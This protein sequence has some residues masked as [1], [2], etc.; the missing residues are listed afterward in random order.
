MPTIC[1]PFGSAPLAGHCSPHNAAQYSM[2]TKQARTRSNYASPSSES[3]HG[4][5][6][7]PGLFQRFPPRFRNPCVASWTRCPRTPHTARCLSRTRL[8]TWV[9]R[10][11]RSAR[12]PRH[13]RT[14]RLTAPAQRG[15]CWRNRRS[16]ITG[17]YENNRVECGAVPEPGPTATLFN[18][19]LD[20]LHADRWVKALGEFRGQGLLPPRIPSGPLLQRLQRSMIP[21]YVAGPRPPARSSADRTAIDRHDSGVPPVVVAGAQFSIALVVA[22]HVPDRD[23]DCVFDRVECCERAVRLASRRERAW[24]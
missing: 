16:H 9:P 22:E 10:P 20:D 18:Q 8:H 14:R 17:Q 6:P 11:T 23:D 4:P 19:A 2:L 1:Y 15:I 3:G 21:I 24:R 5:R 13:S 7:T 12:L